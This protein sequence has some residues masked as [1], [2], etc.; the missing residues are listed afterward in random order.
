MKVASLLSFLPKVSRLKGYRFR[1]YLLK[2]CRLKGCRCTT[3][4]GTLLVSLV[5]PC[6]LRSTL[7]CLVNLNPVSNLLKAKGSSPRTKLPVKLQATRASLAAVAVGDAVD[8]VVEATVV[9]GV[10]DVVGAGLTW[11]PP[12]A[13]LLLLAPLPL[14]DK[15]SPWE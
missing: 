7:P 14:L 5:V 10:V 11:R 2:G 1:A 6:L 12:A 4:W 3:R 15:K 8:S 9:V 13:R